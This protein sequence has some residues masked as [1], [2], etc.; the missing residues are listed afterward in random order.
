[1]GKFTQPLIVDA[2]EKKDFLLFT[3]LSAYV[4][5]AGGCAA[6]RKSVSTDFLNL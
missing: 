5:P 4:L 1:M 6:G 2:V 3:A